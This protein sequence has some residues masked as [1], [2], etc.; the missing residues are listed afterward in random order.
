MDTELY[1]S[2]KSLSLSIPPP[3]HSRA[4]QLATTREDPSSACWSITWGVFCPQMGPYICSYPLAL[5]KDV[6]FDYM[7]VF[8]PQRFQL[9]CCHHFSIFECLH[10]RHFRV[11]S[12]KVFNLLKIFTGC[13]KIGKDNPFQFLDAY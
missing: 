1:K 4:A 10:M 6:F 3:L 7:V 9:I 13:T 11:L 5:V 2:R 12:E 8:C